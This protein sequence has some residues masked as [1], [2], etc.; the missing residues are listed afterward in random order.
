MSIECLVVAFA[1]DSSKYR[2]IFTMD[3]YSQVD[4]SSTSVRATNRSFS[5]LREGPTNAKG[6]QSNMLER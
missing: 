3:V 4:I 1:T 2:Y 5:F 6:D